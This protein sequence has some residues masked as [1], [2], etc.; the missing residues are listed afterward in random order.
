[1][2]RFTLAVIAAGMSS[3]ASGAFA[4][5]GDVSNS[6]DA[7]RAAI[8]TQLKADTSAVSVSVGKIKSLA[9]VRNVAF[10]VSSFDAAGPYRGINATCVT[11]L[12]GEVTELTIDG[13]PATLS[14]GH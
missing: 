9:R 13:K 6:I 8:L 12:T 14:A 2:N 4:G 1:M 7:C 10:K 5:D 11:K 3:M